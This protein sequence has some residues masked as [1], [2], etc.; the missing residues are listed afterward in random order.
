MSD[1]LVQNVPYDKDMQARVDQY[2][3]IRSR[4]APNEDGED[5]TVKSFADGG[6]HRRVEFYEVP[7]STR[8]AEYQ[9]QRVG[10][11][12]HGKKAGKGANPLMNLP[13][14]DF[15]KYVRKDF[16]ETMELAFADEEKQFRPFYPGQDDDDDDCD[17]R[18]MCST[19]SKYKPAAMGSFMMP[20]PT[21]KQSIRSPPDIQS[22][23]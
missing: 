11:Q 7:D 6:Q 4:G 19:Y 13:Q 9:S 22:M 14:K 18:S 2:G 21:A 20:R 12:Q 5:D 3:L 10:Q 17:T 8:M 15:E 23:Y 1:L 16:D